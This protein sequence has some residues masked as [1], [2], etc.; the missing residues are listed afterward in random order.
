MSRQE[1]TQA[2]LEQYKQSFLGQLDHQCL[3]FKTIGSGV[4]ESPKWIQLQEEDEVNGKLIFRN[5][6]V[7]EIGFELEMNA[8]HKGYYIDYME[9]YD[10]FK[11][12]KYDFIRENH[13]TITEGGTM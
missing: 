6:Q 9:L 10:Y 7:P 11:Q 4:R 13:P 8:D 2:I 1:K 3:L 12:L 5:S